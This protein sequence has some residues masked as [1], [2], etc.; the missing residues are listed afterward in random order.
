MS[1][2]GL[3]IKLRLTQL[4]AVSSRVVEMSGEKL[5]FTCE[6]SFG[7][8]LTFFTI[9]IRKDVLFSW[10]VEGTILWYGLERFIPPIIQFDTKSEYGK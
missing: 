3:D 6:G 4:K 1:R 7:L 10:L 9:L 8:V 2:E 5:F